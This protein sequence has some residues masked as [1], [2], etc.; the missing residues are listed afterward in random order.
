MNTYNLKELIGYSKTLQLLYVEDNLEVRENTVDFLKIFFENITLC[1]QGQE[2]L[3]AFKKAHFDLI[4]TDINMPVMNGLEMIQKIK[5]VNPNIPVF[6]LSAHDDAEYLVESIDL[7]IDAYIQKPL[8]PETF[9]A[10]LHKTMDYL[11]KIHAHDTMLNELNQLKEIADRSSIVSRTDIHGNITYINEQFCEISGYTKEEL[12]GKPHSIVRHPDM[13]TAQFKELWDTI[14]KEKKPWFGQLKNQTKSGSAY[15]VDCVINP[16]LDKQGEVQEYLAMRYDVTNLI[17]PKEKLFDEIKRMSNPLLLIGAIEE[18]DILKHFYHLQTIEEI[19]KQFEKD[20][21]NYFTSKLPFKYVY[22]LGEGIFAFLTPYPEAYSQEEVEKELKAFQHN[23]KGSVIQLD[24]YAY[25]I[26]L[27]L[28]YA[29]QKETLF[30]DAMLGIEHAYKQKADFIF[31]NHLAQ[32]EQKQAM[33]NMATIKMIQKAITQQNII[34]F[35][36]PIINNKTGEIEKYESLVRLIDEEEI[37]SPMAFLEIAKKGKYYQQITHI[38]IQN[39]FKQLIECDKEISINLSAID[40]EEEETQRIILSLLEEHKEH[41]HRLIFELL[42]DENIKNFE[43]IKTFIKKVK[44]YNVQIA[45]D[46]FGSGYS[47]FE[48]ILEYHP[49]IL[50]IDGSLIKNI[51]T[52]Q[53]SRDIVETIYSFASKLNIKTVAEFVSNAQ[54]HQIVSKIGIDYSQ[55]FHLGKPSPTLS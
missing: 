50:K 46:D 54:I 42:E 31:A 5:K 2:G 27:T 26:R 4:I 39:S 48:R 40:I 41:T 51:E 45:I 19:E 32:Q 36:Q 20:A 11:Q 16:V 28:S 34:S 21:L 49:D 13:P 10:K 37:I 1:T 3:E 23:V 9:T 6:V 44:T 53:N 17:S 33:E 18:Y 47:N 30:K 15:Y 43:T 24:E 7:D 22:A 14:K 35:F 29:T 12:I 52:N 25:D 38:V 8:T 55:G